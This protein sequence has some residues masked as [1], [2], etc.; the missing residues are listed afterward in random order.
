M[1]KNNA[2]NAPLPISS[3]NGGTGVSVPTANGVMVSNGASPMSAV[4]LLDGQL[5]IGSTGINPVAAYLTAGSGIDIGV[6]GGNITIQANGKLPWTDVTGLVQVAAVNNGYVANNAALVTIT[7]PAT[8]AF[9]DI[10]KVRGFGAGGWSVVLNAGQQ[11]FC[12]TQ[13]STVAGSVDSDNQYDAIE[14]LCVVP[15]TTFIANV[16]QG[17]PN[18]L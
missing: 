1:A 7:M 8:C 4:T 3:T 6:S 13:A 9:G 10:V 2:I 5:L 12:G 14:F 15:N 17:N 18:F 16:E 11:V